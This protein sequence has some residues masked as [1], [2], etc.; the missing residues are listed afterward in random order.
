MKLWRS[1]RELDLQVTAQALPQ[2]VPRRAGQAQVRWLKLWRCGGAVV[3]GGGRLGLH[4]LDA[5]LVARALLG[6]S[7]GA[8]G[9]AD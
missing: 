9:A 2:L 7:Q 5:A 8:G 4:A 1:E 6:P 3:P